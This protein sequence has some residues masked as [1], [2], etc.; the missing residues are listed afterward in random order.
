MFPPAPSALG[1]QLKRKRNRS[2]LSRSPPTPPPAGRWG[3]R[4]QSRPRSDP[5]CLL[6]PPFASC[7]EAGE[8][9][10]P[11]TSVAPAIGTSPNSTTRPRRVRACAAS[12]L[13]GA[14]TTAGDVG[15][16]SAGAFGTSSGK[17][18]ACVLAVSP[19][20][21]RSSAGPLDR[22]RRR[23]SPDPGGAALDEAANLAGAWL[24]PA[25]SDASTVG[26]KRHAI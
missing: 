22:R 7:D 1:R 12:S 23:V 9:D 10:I 3:R 11:P 6:L 2:V 26:P 13:S 15:G 21:E 18:P 14:S 20:V 8:T 19:A 16:P 17:A 4:P 25:S 5:H 24:P